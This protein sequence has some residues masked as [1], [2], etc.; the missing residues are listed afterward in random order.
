M[1]FVSNRS[2]RNLKVSDCTII[3]MGTT[4]VRNDL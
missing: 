1:P 4:V 3:D 2:A